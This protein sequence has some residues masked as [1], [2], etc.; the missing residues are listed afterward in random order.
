MKGA[1]MMAGILMNRTWPS[2]LDPARWMLAEE[3]PAASWGQV[4]VVQNDF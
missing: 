1:L 2:A 3:Q 4:A